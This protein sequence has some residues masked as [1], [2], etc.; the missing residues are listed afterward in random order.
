MDVL[1]GLLDD[2]RRKRDA[3]TEALFAT[4]YLRQGDEV[5]VSE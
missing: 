3:S 4:L 2:W 1:S 5:E